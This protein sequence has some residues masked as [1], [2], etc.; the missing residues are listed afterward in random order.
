MTL[1]VP[2]S[3][4]AEAKLFC[5]GCVDNGMKAQNKTTYDAATL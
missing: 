5:D 4:I 1:P 2:A 3:P